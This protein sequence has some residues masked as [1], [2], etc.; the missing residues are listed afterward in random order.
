MT[1][2]VANVDQTADSFGGWINKTNQLATAL[3]TKVVSTDSNT[4]TGNAAVSNAFTANQ[5]FANTIKGGTASG[6]SANLALTSNVYI[7]PHDANIFVVLG[8]STTGSYTTTIAGNTLSIGT[9]NTVLVGTTVSVNVANLSIS[10]ST[11][12]MANGTG[13]ITGQVLT[14]NGSSVYWANPESLSTINALAEFNI[15]N[16]ITVDR[17]ASTGNTTITLISQNVAGIS[18]QGDSEATGT[19]ADSGAYIRLGVDGTTNNAL[20]SLV[21]GA[22][23]NGI[24][25]SFTNTLA[26]T[27]LIGT[28]GNTNIQL[29]TNGVVLAT[30]TK[31]GNFGIGNTA[32]THKLRV[33]G[34]ASISGNLALSS[35]L[36]VT[37]N[38]SVSGAASVTGNLSVNNSL[39]VTAN[40]FASGFY[41]SNGASVG[42]VI[43]YANG[44]VAFP[45]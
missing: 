10:T 28:T 25:G 2:T 12:V 45:A 15:S 23:N 43:Y 41:Y 8:N 20:L 35:S 17:S 4:A 1:I 32:P 27:L 29:G 9:T 21:Q 40:V 33:D 26:D 3:S 39:T 22:G 5:I 36:S 38:L 14:S 37:S 13:G 18:I 24:G 31:S 19:G 42:V 30:L 11:K 7:N 16:T 6:G 34:T 44:A